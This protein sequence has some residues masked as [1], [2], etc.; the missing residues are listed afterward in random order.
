MNWEVM[1]NATFQQLNK[2]EQIHTSPAKPTVN[3]MIKKN[4]YVNKDRSNS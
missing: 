2:Y 3:S 4:I 1:S